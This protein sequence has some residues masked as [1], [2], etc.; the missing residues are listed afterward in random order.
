MKGLMHHTYFASTKS[1]PG[2]GGQ[3]RKLM[4][5]A[6]NGAG[7]GSQQPAGEIQHSGFPAA[8]RSH[9]GQRFACGQIETVEMPPRMLVELQYRLVKGQNHGVGSSCWVGIRQSH[10]YVYLRQYTTR[11]EVQVWQ[12]AGRSAWNQ[13][14][15]RVLTRKPVS[16]Q[17]RP[18]LGAGTSSVFQTECLLTL[19]CSCYFST[20]ITMPRIIMFWQN[21]K[22]RN[23]GIAARISDA[24][25]T[26]WPARSAS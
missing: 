18:S 1:V 4:A 15:R 8:T 25:I 3:R 24:Y 11:A 2:G 9:N 5:Q 7:V 23:V 14:G 21:T 20:G 6:G 19:P 13:G 26:G 12:G 10:S 16:R 22:I 17:T